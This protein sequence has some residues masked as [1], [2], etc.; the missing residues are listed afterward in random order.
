MCYFLTVAV[1]V[2]Q[3][4]HIDEVFAGPFQTHVTANQSIIAALP[5]GYAVRLVTSGLCSCDL[6][7][8]QSS[9]EDADRW[10]HLRRK[11]KAAGWSE[12]KID[13]ALQQMAASA[14]KSNR[15]ESGLRGDV[16]EGLAMLSRA[17]GSVAFVVHWYSGDVESEPLAL[18]QGLPCHCDDLPQRAKLLVEGELVVVT[19]R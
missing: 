17:V 12:A 10:T 13:R 4:E 14:S 6:Y 9:S 3:I 5:P 19:S 8:R 7:T 1:P 2:K 11:Y 15:P 16:T 18:F